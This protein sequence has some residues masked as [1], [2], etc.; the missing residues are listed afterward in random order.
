MVKRFK[1]NLG[2]PSLDSSHLLIAIA[3]GFGALF[4]AI[5]ALFSYLELAQLD[6]LNARQ[7][8][9]TAEQ[10]IL[11]Q[12]LRQAADDAVVGQ[13]ATLDQLRR[14]RQQ[15]QTALADLAQG[16]EDSGSHNTQ[17]R[18]ELRKIEQSWMPLSQHIEAILGVRESSIAVRKLAEEAREQLPRLRETMTKVAKRLMAENAASALLLEAGFELSRLER[19]EASLDRALRGGAEAGQALEEAIKAS[20]GFAEGL[21][22]LIVGVRGRADASASR[23]ALE[24]ITEQFATLETRTTEIMRRLDN[25]RAATNQLPGL[26][27]AAG[28]VEAALNTLLNQYR[29]AGRHVLLLGVP[30]GTGAVLLF[31]ALSLLSLA[32]LVLI[33]LRDSKTREAAYRTQTER[34]ERAILRLLDELGDLADGDLTVEATVTEDKTGAIADAF[35]YAIEALRALVATINHTA[36]QVAQSTQDSRAIVLRLAEASSAQSLQI[37]QASAAV[38]SL[39]VQ[40]DEVARNAGESA[41]VASRSVE[42]AGRG[43]Q[44]VRDT[45][46]GMDAIREQIQETSKRIKRLGES[47]QEIG[48]IVELIDDIADQTNILALNAAMQ[49]AMA[50][51]AGRGFAVVADEV[52]RLAERS[53][54]ATKQ[55]E[56]LVRTIQAD[57]NEA[58]SSMEASTAGVVEGAHL[59]ENAGEALREIENVS[60]YIAEL[61]KRIA[62]SSQRQS[63]QSAEINDTVQAIRAITEENTE[64][65]R[66]SAESVE[67]LASLANDLQKS[68]AGFRLTS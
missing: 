14:D 4:F 54:N 36:S 57:T 37:T 44:T 31:A 12:Q 15:F 32:A 62:D 49:A 13:A 17:L 53:R 43:A 29:D 41:E 52:Q 23:A 42:V 33:F 24:E 64:G 21:S 45:I 40:I 1:L 28:S 58:V 2:K 22:A 51:E 55:I 9:I 5:L 25:V 48:E 27:T 6:E 34:D 65:T 20:D 8:F 11:T 10:R 16:I 66:Q 61:T 63:R 67:V 59:A 39:T 7:G 19:L 35:N 56:V 68:V 50:G 30:I 26:Q 46:Q 18:A 47:S 3:F 38:Q 60:A